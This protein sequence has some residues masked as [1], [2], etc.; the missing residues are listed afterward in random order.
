MDK[1]NVVTDIRFLDEYE[2][3]RELTPD[4]KLYYIQRDA[5]EA[6]AAH[7]THPSEMGLSKLRRYAD[8]TVCNNG[9]LADLR[10]IVGNLE[11][12]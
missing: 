10:G 4:F 1:L 11:F 8:V 2:A 5:A 9:T 3:F 7:D 6:R 12:R